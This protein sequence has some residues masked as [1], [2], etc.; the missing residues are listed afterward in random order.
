MI[1]AALVSLFF[2]P[3][4]AQPRKISRM[5]ELPAYLSGRPEQLVFHEAYTVSFNSSAR[6]PNWSAWMLTSE[7]TEGEEARS[8]TEAFAVDPEIKSGCPSGRDYQFA[9]YGYD[10][11]HM[12][13]AMDNR[14]SATAMKE[15]F[16]M[17]NMCPQKHELNGGSWK[18]LEEKCHRW[19]KEFGCLY[20][21]CGPVLSDGEILDKIGPDERI[22]APQRFFKAVLR[23]DSVAKSAAA[24][25][26]DQSGRWVAV[27]VDEAERI[28]GLDLFHNLPDREE[29]KIEARLDSLAWRF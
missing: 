16:Y 25:I 23:Y 4:Q 29:R 3:L 6:I 14:W 20:I 28:T 13:P 24:F 8:G 19:A 7:H 2:L 5:L 9:V 10:R 12:C 11:G 15:C 17:S 18:N 21:C 1:L 22:V 27:T 26:F